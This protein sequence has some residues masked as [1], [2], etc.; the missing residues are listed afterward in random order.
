VR[1]TRPFSRPFSRPELAEADAE[2]LGIGELGGGDDRVLAWSPLA[3]GGVAAATQAGLHAVTPTGKVFARP[4]TDISKAAWDSESS[5]LAVWWVDS[6]QPLALEVV[7]QARLPDMIYDRVRSSVLVSAE[8]ALDGGRSVWVALRRGA[9][10]RFLTQAVAS[11]GVRLDDP[12]VASQ[13][14]AVKARLRADAGLD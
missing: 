12:A 5:A 2:L 1:L 10:D 9:D 13:V 6:R 3:L 4:W 14:A 8:V 7:D 11:P